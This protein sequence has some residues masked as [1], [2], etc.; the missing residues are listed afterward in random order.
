[1]EAVLKQ[2]R[3]NKQ[4]YYNERIE[5]LDGSGLDVLAEL[6]QQ[7]PVPNRLNLRRKA[8]LRKLVETGRMSQ[9]AAE[10]FFD[11]ALHK[12]ILSNAGTRTRLH[13]DVPI[14]SMKAF[15]VKEFGL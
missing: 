9:E 7:T 3:E 6:L 1:L 13:Y 11:S 2:G 5:S 15:L 10:Q 4:T 12:G 14:P 8:L